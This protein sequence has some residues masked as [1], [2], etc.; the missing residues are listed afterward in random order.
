VAIPAAFF[1]SVIVYILQR[2]KIPKLEYD[3]F[4]KKKNERGIESEVRYF[5]RVRREGGEGDAEGVRGYVGI[6]NK[7]D[8]QEG[9]WLRD[10][11]PSVDITLNKYLI[12]F[13]TFEHNGKVIITFHG[14]DY[15]P[16]K[17]DFQTRLEKSLY[18]NHK[19]DKLIVETYSS[20]G[21][22][23]K[24]RLEKKIQDIVDEANQILP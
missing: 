16:D 4:W 24:K 13:K 23:K 19:E 11:N 10:P 1:G 12:L 7:L 5:V 15:D 9:A 3:G 2:R 6:Q 20:R 17:P 22:I 18:E 14:I 8:L 21:R